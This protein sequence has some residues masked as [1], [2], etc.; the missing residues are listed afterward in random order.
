MSLPTELRVMVYK[1]LLTE[2][3]QQT[4]RKYPRHIPICD[5]LERSSVSKESAKEA[6]TFYLSFNNIIY[7]SSRAACLWL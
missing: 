1:Y 6:Y 7:D 2:D 4:A 3:V 5:A